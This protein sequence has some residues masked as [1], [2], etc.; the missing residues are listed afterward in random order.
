MV[1]SS[2]QRDVCERDQQHRFICS[3]CCAVCRWSRCMNEICSD[4]AVGLTRHCWSAEILLQREVITDQCHGSPLLLMYGVSTG[5]RCT[6]AL[7]LA[8]YKCACL[9]YRRPQCLKAA[10]ALRFVIGNHTCYINT[11]SHQLTACKMRL[12]SLVNAFH[13]S[14]LTC[15][16]LCEWFL[17]DQLNYLVL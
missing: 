15:P 16:S 13:V 14:C 8:A 10:L 17:G 3:V 1:V 12:L 6:C 5:V 2:L 11:A 4:T 7:L 9:H